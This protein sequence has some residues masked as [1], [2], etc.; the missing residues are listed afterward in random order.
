MILGNLSLLCNFRLYR[1]DKVK[2]IHL[3]HFDLYVLH[4]KWSFCMLSIS[5]ILQVTIQYA[6]LILIGSLL[7]QIHQ[8][9]KLSEYSA[10]DQQFF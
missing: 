10:V 3:L 9:L 4:R 5:T 1:N 6:M 8:L 2:S 7:H